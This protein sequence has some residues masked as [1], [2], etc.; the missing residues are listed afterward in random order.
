MQINHANNV[1]IITT[2]ELRELL[3]D[4]LTAVSEEGRRVIV[5]RHGK[6]LA[7][8]MPMDDLMLVER[9]EAKIDAVLGLAAYEEL[10]AG[11]VMTLDEVRAR[12][13]T[14]P[15]AARDEA[16]LPCVEEVQ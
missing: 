13:L 2:A 1:H 4:T 14:A 11:R 10:R 9:M 3:G 8:L 6:P 16:G 15:A 7:V 5:T 12:S